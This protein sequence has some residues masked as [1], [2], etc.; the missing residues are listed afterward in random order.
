MAA[1][2]WFKNTAAPSSAVVELALDDEIADAERCMLLCEPGP[3][4]VPYCFPAWK[5]YEKREWFALA[6]SD[7]GNSE[8]THR[9][10]QQIETK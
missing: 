4:L 7:N 1:P 2:T 9:P 6:C 10:R 3:L 5:L 8:Y